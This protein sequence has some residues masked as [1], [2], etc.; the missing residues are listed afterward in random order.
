MSKYDD[1]KNIVDYLKAENATYDK[2]V[3]A[4]WIADYCCINESHRSC[5]R[6]RKLVKDAMKFFSIPIGTN[7]KGFY[8]IKTG[9]EMQRYCNSLLKRQ[10]GITDTIDVTYEAWKARKRRSKRK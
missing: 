10:V 9:Q 3:P 8:I 6:T 7:H 4:T 1:C 2:P 5:P